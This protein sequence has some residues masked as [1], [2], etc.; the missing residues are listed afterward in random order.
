[1]KAQKNINVDMYRVVG[2]LNPFIM[3][4]YLDKDA[5]EHTGLMMLD[6]GSNVNFL[7]NEVDKHIGDLCRHNGTELEIIDS[8]GEVMGINCVHFSFAFGGMQFNEDFGIKEDCC[9]GSVGD[10]SIIGIL[11]TKFMQQHGLVIDYSDFT[12]HTSVLHHTGLCASECDFIFPMET[13]LKNFG[14]PV[15]A[16]HHEETDIAVLADTGSTENV[17]SAQ[18]ISLCKLKC[19]YTG[20]TDTMRGLV[21]C[22]EGQRANTHFN[23]LSLR[24]KGAEGVPFYDSF[25][26]INHS[27]D[28]EYDPNED[29][30]YTIE[31][32]IGS[33]FMAKQ[34][35]T[36][37]FA[38]KVIYKHKHQTI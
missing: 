7:S 16:I 24:E 31:G 30:R 2:D 9:L 19:E 29:Q 20:D 26:V 18:C 35:W 11:G 27:V 17:V 1:M 13:G 32:M 38:Q 15:L 37:D 10:L 6:S 23:L 33:P 5:D 25:I 34:G 8:V 28:E 3:V 12:V 14:V 22:S 21:G 36:L 4:D